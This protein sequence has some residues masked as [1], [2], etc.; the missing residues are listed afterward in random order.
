[1]TTHL[2]EV[3]R[4]DTYREPGQAYPS[5]LMLARGRVIGTPRRVTFAV[6]ARAAHDL[7]LTLDANPG[8]LIVVEVEGWQM[9]EMN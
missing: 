5:S 9:Q 2:I 4:I 8:A 1:M 6:D 3:E 7:R